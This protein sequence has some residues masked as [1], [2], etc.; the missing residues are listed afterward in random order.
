MTNQAKQTEIK[1]FGLTVRARKALCSV[2]L[3]GGLF[4]GQAMQAAVPAPTI[5]DRVAA[6]R[7]ELNKRI[8]S[9]QELG[10]TEAIQKLPYTQ[11]QVASWLNWVNW[12][13]WNNWRDWN[14]WHNWNNWS[15][16]INY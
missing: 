13:N 5:P 1:K 10:G 16:W 15:Y 14:N 11:V 9:A 2:F 6:V 8:L 12:P 4:G 3:A 7:T